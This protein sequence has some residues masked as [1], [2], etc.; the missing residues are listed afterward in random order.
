MIDKQTIEGIKE[1]LPVH[2]VASKHLTL[3]KKGSNYFSLCPFHTETTAS[4]CVPAP[5]AKIQ[6]FKCF[7]CQKTGDVIALHEHFTGSSFIEA[8]EQLAKETNT[9]ITQT[10]Q[11]PV[12]PY[13]TIAKAKDAPIAND[14][15][16]T[17]L[18][19]WQGLLPNS[20]AAEYLQK[21]KIPLE[22]AVRCGA[23]YI[24]ANEHYENLYGERIV[25]PHTMADGSIISLYGRSL[26]DERKHCHLSGAKGLFNAPALNLADDLWLVEGVFDAL[27]L[28]AYG[29]EKTVAVFGLDGMDMRWLRGQKKIIVFFDYDEAGNK[30]YQK[31]A[32]EAEY[33][34]IKT[35]R[36]EADIL[37]GYKDFSEY[38]QNA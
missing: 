26:N 8:V 16:I 9:N 25:F 12:T 17:C 38:W 1:R 34:G 7:G 10:A 22:I 33:W 13:K 29:I 24:P 28:M 36:Y 18:K 21:R 20:P 23:G 30:A 31:F 32:L 2:A 19:R 35:F 37:N 15:V 6:T 3:T 4:F 14:T 5:E 11:K 27:A